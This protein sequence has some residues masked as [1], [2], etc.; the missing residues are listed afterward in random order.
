MA[1]SRGLSFELVP[2][3]VKQ[4]LSESV[5]LIWTGL[6]TIGQGL[7]K[8]YGGLVAMRFLIGLFE[9]GLVPGK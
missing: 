9:A 4:W 6:A 7:V 8:S 1:E 2:R 5:V 3:T